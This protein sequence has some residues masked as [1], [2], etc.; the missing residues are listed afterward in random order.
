MKNVIWY[1]RPN[2]D[3]N[4]FTPGWNKGRKKGLSYAV[5]WDD[6]FQGVRFPT[7]QEAESWINGFVNDEESMSHW[8]IR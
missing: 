8:N 7:I 4:S 1:H 3:L 2:G 6:E 5:Y